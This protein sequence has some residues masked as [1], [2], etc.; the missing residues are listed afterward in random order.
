MAWWTV[1]GA[2]IIAMLWP[3]EG[4]ISNDGVQYVSGA[5]NLLAGQGYSTSIL[6]FD[7]HYRTGTLPAPQTVWPPG[8]SLL[9]AGISAV[10]LDP[11][12]AARLVPRLCFLLFLPLCYLLA[13]RLDLPPRWAMFSTFWIGGVAEWWMYTTMPNS[14]VPFTVLA[15][16][17]V[18]AVPHRHEGSR[19]WAWVGLLAALAASLRYAGAFLLLA[20]GLVAALDVIA[21]SRLSARWRVASILWY[22]LGSTPFALVL[23]RNVLLVGTPSGG[24]AKPMRQPLTD[25]LTVTAS[26][27]GDLVAGVALLDLQAFSFRAIIAGLSL[28]GIAYFG[29]RTLRALGRQGTWT[30]AMADARALA[31]VAFPLVYLPAVIITASRTMVSFGPRFLLP[32]VPPL[33]LVITYLLHAAE[34]P[35]PSE[36]GRSKGSRMLAP[37][38][39]LLAV[40][41]AQAGSVEERWRIRSYHPQPDTTLAQWIGKHVPAGEAIMLLGGSQQLAFHLGRPAAVIPHQRWTARSWDEPM[42]RETVRTYR[43]RTVLCTESPA[44]ADYGAF[45]NGILAGGTPSWAQEVD[46]TESTRILL[47]RA[48]GAG[49]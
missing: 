36:N 43:I 23:V 27:L 34:D 44:E 33:I 6:F 21:R 7:E 19:A 28:A 25:L 46:R 39:A 4:G 22:S 30:I 16:A 26:S 3:R 40:L 14:E 47:V 12:A 29:L 18:A 38:M 9:V 45:L 17:A 8:Y 41:A 15:L 32:I 10:G 37:G 31:V 42:V 49:R 24:N 20:L 2:L 35:K 5:Q 13:R 1:I 48:E 11:D